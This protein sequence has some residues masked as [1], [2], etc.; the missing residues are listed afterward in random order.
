MEHESDNDVLII[1]DEN[2]EQ[3][4]I[5]FKREPST[6]DLFKRIDEVLTDE[7]N[8][9]KSRHVDIAPSQ[10]AVSSSRQKR[11]FEP[12]QTPDRGVP[13]IVPGSVTNV[14]TVTPNITV[15]PIVAG[16]SGLSEIFLNRLGPI[17]PSLASRLGPSRS[18]DSA[19]RSSTPTEET[20]VKRPRGPDRRPE[21]YRALTQQGLATLQLPKLVRHEVNRPFYAATH[22]NRNELLWRELTHKDRMA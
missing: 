3:I 1:D 14:T 22:Y 7:P 8:M 19:P 17:V 13:R 6:E 12:V 4:T 11:A 15:T 21:Q 20:K 5:E 18:T 16:T 10:P 2:D 9:S